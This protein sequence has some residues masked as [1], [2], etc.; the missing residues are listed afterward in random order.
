VESIENQIAGTPEQ[1]KAGGQ[2]DVQAREDARLL[3]A[4]AEGDQH[5]L[6]ALYRHRGSLL[7]SLLFRMLLNEMEAQETTQDAF[8][9][10]WRRAGNYDSD[11]SSPVAWMV[12]ITRG[13]AMDRLR[14]RSRRTAGLA[15]YEQEVASLEVEVNAG[16]RQAERDE[17]A[18]AC[19]A[20]LNSLPEPQGR[21]LQLA[22]FRGWTHEEISKAV[23]E[24]LGT[25]K[26]RI[27]RG[28]LAL[29]QVLK[30]YHG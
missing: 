15:A 9:Q 28:L 22:F 21:A 12:M 20:A 8:L 11:R 29:R 30:E 3:A 17:L 26:A 14:A 16:P 18:D 2:Q 24:P 23:G 5:A 13:L 7:Y 27:R 4:I 25:V 1:Q 6:A 19:A 10:I